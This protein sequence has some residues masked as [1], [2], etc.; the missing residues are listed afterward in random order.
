MCGIAGFSALPGAGADAGRLAAL[1]ASHLRH[2]G[3]HGTWVEG[4]AEFALGMT[5]LAIVDPGSRHEPFRGEAG[6]SL[7]A[8]NG[9]IHNYRELREGLPSHEFLT[10]TDT[11]VV[12]HHL[13]ET[14]W[15]GIGAL[16]DDFA[17]AWW[18]GRTR[19]GLLARDRLGVRPLYYAATP[20]GLAFCSE[21]RPLLL[22]CPSLRIL[23]VF[24]MD[25]YLESRFVPSPNT[26]FAG[27]NKVSPGEIVFFSNGR[28]TSAAL[29]PFSAPEIGS[30][31][32]PIEAVEEVRLRF[33]E[34]IR[35]RIPDTVP[36]AVLLSGGLDSSY[37]AAVATGTFGRPIRVISIGYPP[38][39]D[40]QGLSEHQ[41]AEHVGRILGADRE[42]LMATPQA[43]R[44]AA[45]EFSESLDEPIADAPSVLLSAALEAARENVRVVL[46]GE[47][48]DE[49]FGGYALYR[50]YRDRPNSYPGMGVLLER[51]QRAKF[52]MPESL[53]DRAPRSLPTDTSDPN[54][55]LELD[56]RG[57]LCDNLLI[58]ADRAA[59]RSSI[60]VRVPY[61]DINLA[62]Y[63]ASLPFA[64]KVTETTDKMVLRRAAGNLL[65]AAVA[66]RPKA[67][68]PL[69]LGAWLRGPLREWALDLCSSLSRREGIRTDGTTRFVNSYFAGPGDRHAD[70]VMWALVALELFF[71]TQLDD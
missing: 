36:F 65:P 43:F 54:S 24:A 26:A 62:T 55:M 3:P 30:A 2:R 34:A 57:W 27:V 50:T 28:R 49:L 37:I 13:E 67:G 46:A 68:F 19:S 38:A 14:G 39:D 5:R 22:A 1:M 16:R 60:E 61:L 35:V 59:M 25:R 21:L 32:Q 18:D 23:D 52:L 7:F 10:E 53:E 45:I 63:A 70:H 8:M 42:V 20:D 33:A 71:R 44:Q 9:E 64:L 51:S 29:I 48:A 47:G 15:E 12:G 41:A 17:L 58:R 4:S 31:I 11:E 69:P 6:S 66:S 40:P 56:L